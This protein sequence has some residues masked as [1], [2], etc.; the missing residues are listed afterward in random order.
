M[1]FIRRPQ[2]HWFFIMIVFSICVI[3]NHEGVASASGHQHNGITLFN[4]EKVAKCLVFHS[5]SGAMQVH[6]AS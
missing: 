2:A 3:L 1:F 4:Q 5:H 6:H